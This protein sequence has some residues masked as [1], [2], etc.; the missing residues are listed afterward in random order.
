MSV[1]PGMERRTKKRAGSLSSQ[2]QFPESHRS[3]GDHLNGQFVS[4]QKAD[5]KQRVGFG[6]VD[7]GQSPFAGPGNGRLVY[8]E[9]T[10]TAISQENA[11]SSSKREIQRGDEG[12]WKSERA[13]VARIQDCIDWALAAI[14]THNHEAYHRLTL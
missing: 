3:A 1:V 13:C 7:R 14:G 8:V 12:R 10:L 6:N 9:S 11:A 2:S 4:K 5:A